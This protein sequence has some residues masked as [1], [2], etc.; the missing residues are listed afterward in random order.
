LSQDVSS[1]YGRILELEPSNNLF[2]SISINIFSYILWLILIKIVCQISGIEF[3]ITADEDVDEGVNV[4]G[5]LPN[6]NSKVELMRGV[7]Y[8]LIFILLLFA[9]Y[10]HIN[11]A[12]KKIKRCYKVLRYDDHQ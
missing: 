3:N 12:L 1:K 8:D 6:L 9:L 11:Q 2:I 4:K 10:Q 7:V 5:N